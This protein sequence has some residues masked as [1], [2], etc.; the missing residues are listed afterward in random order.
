LPKPI[1]GSRKDFSLCAAVLIVLVPLGVAHAANF[2]T[3][4]TFT[5]PP[6]DGGNPWSSLVA[7]KTG[8]L[9]GTTFLGGST[10]ACRG[11]AAIGCGTVFK[12]TPD[13]SETV[14]H[15]FTGQPDGALPLAGLV[16]DRNGNLYGTT[17]RGG[18][19]NKGAVFEVAS[20]GAESMLYSFD[21]RHGENPEARL[22]IDGEGN[23]YGTTAYGGDKKCPDRV[24][25][26]GCGVVFRIAPDGTEKVLHAFA[27]GVEGN[28]PLGGLVMDA[29]GNLYGMTQLGGLGYGNVFEIAPGG[30]ETVLH[31]FQGI[32]DGARPAGE[33]IMD[34]AGN[35]YGT[36]A[37]GGSACGHSVFGCGTVFKLEPNGN[38]TVLHGFCE[39][40]DD[41]IVPDA[42]LVADANGNLY[43][44]T[45]FFGGECRFECGTVFKLA[46]AGKETLL[47]VLD[48]RNSY[49]PGA[50]L[51]L[52]KGH[53]FGTASSG[54]HCTDSNHKCGSVFELRK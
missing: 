34:R 37:F 18:A 31:T 21:G 47:Q 4:Y 44:T 46:P 48:T 5:G 49:E 45:L 33:L 35:L 38:E 26:S 19:F 1:A 20:N 25:R 50:S 6:G 7:D 13:G 24:E 15:A 43:G 40:C 23:L 42:G 32:P 52:V 53:L 12:V 30:T 8:N 3:L 36:T 28:E 16:A 41:G 17:M 51:L 39:S 27:N 10:D 2:S 29:S 9:Y 11:N 14:L 54:F 22:I